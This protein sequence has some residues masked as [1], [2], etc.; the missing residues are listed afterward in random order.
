[1]TSLTMLAYGFST[2][3][4]RR[5][6]SLSLL[7]RNKETTVWGVQQLV[8]SKNRG[9]IKHERCIALLDAVPSPHT[10]TW[11]ESFVH[12]QP[13]LRVLLGQALALLSIDP[14]AF[15]P[16]GLPFSALLPWG[17]EAPATVQAK[18]S[19]RLA[20]LTFYTR[21][22][23]WCLGTTLKLLTFSSN[24]SEDFAKVSLNA[25]EMPVT[26]GLTWCP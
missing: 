13:A 22:G 15:T 2:I 11:G 4:G 8:G 24:L 16:A 26:L 6:K 10:V 18:P 7:Q 20:L 23:W 21:H 3:S 25:A 9:S 14:Q 12:P 19:S 1:M 5:R 17:T